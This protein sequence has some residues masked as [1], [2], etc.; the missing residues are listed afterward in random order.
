MS[1][2]KSKKQ[3]TENEPLYASDSS[4]DDYN[5]DEVEEDDDEEELL[6]FEDLKI[7][8]RTCFNNSIFCLSDKKTYGFLSTKS[9]KLVELPDCP[10][11]TPLQLFD[12]DY[13]HLSR[14]TVFSCPLKK[15]R[16]KLEYEKNY[17]LWEPT[18]S[19]KAYTG[20]SDV[21]P[22]EPLSFSFD[23]CT[24]RFKLKPSNLIVTYTMSAALELTF[25]HQLNLSLCALQ[26]HKTTGKLRLID[27]KVVD[28][29]T[30]LSKFKARLL[31]LFTSL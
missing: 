17:K 21:E 28:F 5:E 8:V 19:V 15:L 2:S 25:A 31:R 7:G 13:N 6:R 1:E 14:S 10:Q 9:R 30:H 22:V 11:S 20:L 26:L 27:I 4:E 24:M 23:D 18:A 12:K 16:A 3:R 29:N